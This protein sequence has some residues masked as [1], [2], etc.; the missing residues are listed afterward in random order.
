MRCWHASC[1]VVSYCLSDDAEEVSELGCT[2][3]ACTAPERRSE[4][5]DTRLHEHRAASC[6]RMIAAP[7][8]VQSGI[9]I[10]WNGQ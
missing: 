2:A 8:S 4:S 3:Y 6:S 7:P 1:E 9:D 10:D 5:S